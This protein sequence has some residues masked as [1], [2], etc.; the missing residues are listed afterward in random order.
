MLLTTNTYPLVAPISFRLS[1][2]CLVNGLAVS[3]SKIHNARSRRR[4]PDLPPASYA[5]ARHILHWRSPTT[6]KPHYR[7]CGNTRKAR[8]RET[9]TKIRMPRLSTQEDCLGGTI[10]VRDKVA[11]EHAHTKEPV[12][13]C[14]GA[15]YRVSAGV[16]SD[17]LLW[18]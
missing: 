17:G 2:V 13:P 10:I 18:C 15:L 9:L 3:C 12:Q 11:H 5:S 4:C 14:S 7:E 8:T 16:L 1:P 6:K